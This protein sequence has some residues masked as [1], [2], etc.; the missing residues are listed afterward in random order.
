MKNRIKDQFLEEYVLTASIIKW[1]SLSILIGCSVGFITSL[2]IKLIHSGSHY[3]MKIHNYY[4]FLPIALFLS[5]FIILKLA[6]DAEGHGTEKAIEAVHK[7]PN[8]IDLKIIPIKLITTFIT[9]IF[10][11][12]VGEEGPATQIGAG[13]ASFFA[14][15]FKVRRVDS[16]RLVVCGI[17]AGFVGVFG[18]PVGAA[19]FSSEV[20]FIGNISYLSLF[21]S[22]ISCFVSY[23]VG[24]FMGTKPL[25]Y[26]FIDINRITI[27]DR[28]TRL[29]IFGIIIG[30]LARVFIQLVNFC[31]EFFKSIKIYKPLKGLIGG[32]IIIIFVFI[33]NSTSFLGVGQNVINHAING[34][35]LCPYLFLQKMVATCVTLASGGSG[36]ILT[37]MFFIG[38]TVGNFWG[39][40]VN[41]SISFYSALGMVAFLGACA[42]T[43]IAAVVISM[44]LFGGNVGMYASIVCLISY[45]IVGHKSIY[46]TQIVSYSKSPSLDINMN[47]EVKDVENIGVNNKKLMEIIK[48]K[49]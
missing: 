17:G 34:K 39:T 47:C 18:S 1:T 37:P 40:L 10:G 27:V 45:I 6:P 41:G 13:V 44:E 24:R 7:N 26:Y 15:I 29:L 2:F 14:R 31:E 35:Q 42:N 22:L 19:I 43:P 12:S 5:S 25:V 23:Y 49:K 48:L 21:P 4:L 11:G 3:I 28:F 9:I 33:T 32:I 8:K 30:V 16:K 20:L 46:P 38:S 36:G